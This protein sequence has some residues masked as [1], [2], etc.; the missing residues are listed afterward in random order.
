MSGNPVKPMMG[1]CGKIPS[2]GDFLAQDLPIDFI[3]SW[4]EW[5]QAVMAVSREQLADAWLPAYLTSPVWHFALSAGVCTES[6]MVGTLI[7]SVDLVGRHFPFTLA[8]AVD[9]SPI[10]A[11]QQK[12]QHAQAE[13]LILRTLDDDFELSSWLA[14][15]SSL[16][17]AW[18]TDK[19][20]T[21]S[22]VNE[23]NA[24]QAWAIEANIDLNLQGLLHQSYVHQFGRY[25][26]WWTSGS[27][28]VAP[29]LLVT[30]GLPQISQFAGML[31]GGWQQ[32]NWLPKTIKF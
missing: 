14:E 32:W 2:H 16:D 5:L 3:D 1:I 15:L 28:R 8:A 7:P 30:S 22:S 20:I 24:R 31:A 11:W 23:P 21:T 4:N 27:E 26:L 17:M 29:C 19:R 12:Q 9:V 18:S 13:E 10:Q 25:C 6:P